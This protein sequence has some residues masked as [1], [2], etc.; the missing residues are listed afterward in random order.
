MDYRHF[1]VKDTFNKCNS[2]NRTDIL[3]F[4]C[5][6]LENCK[7]LEKVMIKDNLVLIFWGKSPGDEAVIKESEP[8]SRQSVGGRGADDNKEVN[9]GTALV[10][11]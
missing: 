2:H 9:S 3:V 11:G 8:I 5:S 1:K 7:L 4:C 10:K 6:S